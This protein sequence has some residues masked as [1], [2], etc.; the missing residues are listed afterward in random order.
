M[1]Y[2]TS[3]SIYIVVLAQSATVYIVGV[4]W[5][6]LCGKEFRKTTFMNYVIQL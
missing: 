2:S 5:E 6:Y 4:V 1:Q 3:C